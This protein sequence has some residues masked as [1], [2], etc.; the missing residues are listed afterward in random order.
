[1]DLQFREYTFPRLIPATAVDDFRLSQFKPSLLWRVD[2]D[3]VLDPVQ[4]LPFY[5]GLR[6]SRLSATE[7]P[8]KAVGTL[9]GWAG[10]RARGEELDGAF[11]AVEFARVE[12]V[13]IATPEDASTIRAQV[14]DAV[15]TNL[16]LLGM[17]V[18]TVVGEPCMPIEEI[19]Q[20]REQAT[21]AADVPVIDIET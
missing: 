5:H 17:S 1:A 21:S 7:L 15:T 20:R 8:I 12:H 18:Q 6:G 13:W 2:G 3:H 19:A 14:L 11:R 4:C 16:T 10:R 9:G